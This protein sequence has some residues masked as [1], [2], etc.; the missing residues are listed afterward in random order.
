MLYKNFKNC[1]TIQNKEKYI[2]YRN[3][4]KTVLKKAQ[5]EFYSKKLK[6]LSGNLHQTWKLLGTI[7]KNQSHKDS[8]DTFTVNGRKIDDKN[9]IVNHLNEYFIN[10][11]II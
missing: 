2:K 9:E 10:I 6:S 3:K 7:I 11:G 8:M 5:K 1:G 4:L